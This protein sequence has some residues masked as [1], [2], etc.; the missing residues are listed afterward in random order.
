MENIVFGNQINQNKNIQRYGK[1][2]IQEIII[3][4]KYRIKYLFWKV[5]VLDDFNEKWEGVDREIKKDSV[6]YSY[7][8]GLI[9]KNGQS[10]GGNLTVWDGE[11]K[12]VTGS[13][14][15]YGTGIQ[16]DSNI[17]YK[18]CKD[19][20]MGEWCLVDENGIP[21]ID[22]KYKEWEEKLKL[23]QERLQPKR[24]QTLYD[25]G[26]DNIKI[27]PPKTNQQKSNIIYVNGGKENV[28]KKNMVYYNPRGA[29]NENKPLVRITRK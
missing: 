7:L 26:I 12:N 16:G 10:F 29:N 11:E 20:Y 25:N 14:Y 1:P 21:Y 9:L 13:P 6:E 17:D 3:A 23:A 15:W 24:Q 22:R 2:V 18:T 4:N 27:T 19:L 8:K 5:T 28:E